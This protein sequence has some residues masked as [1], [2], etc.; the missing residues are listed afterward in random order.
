MQP[1]QLKRAIVIEMTVL[2]LKQDENFSAVPYKDTKNLWTY[3]YGE[4]S[5]NP[6]KN[7]SEKDAEDLLRKRVVEFA[8]SLD[9]NVPWWTNLDVVRQSALLNMH[10]NMGNRLWVFE[11]MLTALQKG[12]YHKAALEILYE[13]GKPS[14]YWTDVKHR[15]LRVAHAVRY[16]TLEFAENIVTNDSVT[17]GYTDITFTA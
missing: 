6:P 16:G 4:R 2:I 5:N 13:K 15:A 7:I 12:Q 1:E 14:G 8:T 3:G 17:S 11:Q 10:Y 9:R